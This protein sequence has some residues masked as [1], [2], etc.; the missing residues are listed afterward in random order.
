[1]TNITKDRKIELAKQ[2][3]SELKSNIGNL[4]WDYADIFAQNSEEHDYVANLEVTAAVFV[5]E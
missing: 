4:L 5:N 3:E 1:M 2:V